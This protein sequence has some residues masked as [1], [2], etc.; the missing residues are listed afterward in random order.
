MKSRSLAAIF[1]FAL[2]LSGSAARAQSIIYDNTTTSL[3]NDMPLLPAWLN[4]SEEAGDDI[5]LWGTDREVVSLKLLFTYRG[6]QPGTIDL[7]IRFRSVIEEDQT[8]GDIF[9]DSGIIP[10]VPTI[11]GINDYNFAIPHV[12]VPDHFVWTV[13]AY[14]RQGSV[15][16]LGPSYFNPATVGFSDDFFWL[17]GSGG[18]WTNYSWGGDPYANFA[19]RFTAVPEPISL[20]GLSWGCFSLARLRR[21]NRLSKR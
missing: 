5:W 21:A 11:G 3:N 2:L 7:R 12:F 17:H 15:G 13:Q 18:D 6:T 4:D 19:A 14:N 9:F 16:E 10:A 20:L 8:P 1:G